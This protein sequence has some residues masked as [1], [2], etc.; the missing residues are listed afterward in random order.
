[1][2]RDTNVP[3]VDEVIHLKSRKKEKEIKKMSEEFS[4]TK[5]SILGAVSKLT[6]VF[7]SYKFGCNLAPLQRLSGLTTWNTRSSTRTVPGIVFI[8]K[9]VLRS[10]G[11]LT[12]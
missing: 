6:I 1:M 7:R 4:R 2:S 12:F 5:N 11:P 3:R 9:W 10:T 8:Q